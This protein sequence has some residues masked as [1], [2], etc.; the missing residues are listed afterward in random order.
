MLHLG[1]D[2]LVMCLLEVRVVNKGNVL[3]FGMVAFK[4]G[5]LNAGPRGDDEL[6]GDGL[7][8]DGVR[9]RPLVEGEGL[10]LGDGELRVL[11]G[12][13]LQ[14]WRLLFEMASFVCYEAMG[15]KEGDLVY[16]V[17]MGYETMAFKGYL[18]FGF[19]ISL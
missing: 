11:R 5:D 6:R 2:G 1:G 13:D 19:V 12:D 16:F 17:L 4:E 10:P 15:F 9:L 14:G 18:M 3:D 8:G 7:R